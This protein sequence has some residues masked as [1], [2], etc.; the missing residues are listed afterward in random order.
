M[1]VIWTVLGMPGKAIHRLASAAGRLKIHSV[2]DCGGTTS[3]HNLSD[4]YCCCYLCIEETVPARLIGQHLACLTAGFGGL[5][6]HLTGAGGQ[7]IEGLGICV[8][9]LDDIGPS[10]NLQRGHAIKDCLLG[11]SQKMLK[12][13]ILLCG[14]LCMQHCY[15]QSLLG[16]ESLSTQS[17]CL[18]VCSKFCCQDQQDFQVCIVYL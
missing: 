10:R 17:A 12:Q 13:Q 4:S 2:Y 16:W 5:Q 7:H 8:A 18:S 6:E 15:Q 14:I 1:N 11:S 3:E 9:L